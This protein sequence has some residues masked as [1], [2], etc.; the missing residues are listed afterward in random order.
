MKPAETKAIISIFT[1]AR[2]QYGQFFQFMMCLSV[3]RQY[4]LSSQHGQGAF[5]SLYS[6][7]LLCHNFR[8]YTPFQIRKAVLYYP[9]KLI[10]CNFFDSF[11]FHAGS[12]SDL[13]LMGS[14]LRPP[15]R[16]MLFSL[17]RS[18]IFPTYS[19]VFAW[20]KGPNAIALFASELSSSNT[21]KILI[22]S[23]S[24][25]QGMWFWAIINFL[26]GTLFSCAKDT[27]V[28]YMNFLPPFGSSIFT[29]GA[30]LRKPSI[31]PSSRE[32]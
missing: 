16:H 26:K 18:S 6:L 23:R 21:A 7:F 2:N 17:S 4:Q 31:A 9:R 22:L 25:K 1:L 19:I 20:K 29:K 10:G 27:Q 30:R 3:C 11:S 15:R 13:T 5:K 12:I 14:F 8:Y 24:L 32:N 28:S